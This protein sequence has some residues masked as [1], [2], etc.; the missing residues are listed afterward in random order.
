MAKS[1]IKLITYGDVTRFS[2]AKRESILEM[3]DLLEMQKDSYEWFKT[4]GLKEV[5]DDVSP[6]IDYN[7]NLIL[8]FLG[9]ELSSDLKY[10]Q[11]ECKERDTSYSAPLKLKVR[12]IYKE[13]QEIKEQEVFVGNI[14]IMTESGSFVIN[15]AERV[16]VSQ[17]VRSPGIY[18]EMNYDKTGKPLGL[19]TIIPNRGAWLEYET[20]SKDVFYVRVDRT[21]KLPVT[22]LIRAVGVSSDEQI[23]EL[24]GEDPKILASM[25]KDTSKSYD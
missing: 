5:L 17:L 20:D 23:L 22:C 11:E 1:P 10:T 13:T 7:N 3:P 6:I 12:L 2:Y 21:R 25:E 9:Y 24:F 19:S 18:Y 16:V 14:P 8:E 15:G 4:D